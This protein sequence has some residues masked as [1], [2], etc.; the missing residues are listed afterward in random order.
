MDDARVSLQF[1]N[2]DFKERSSTVGTD[3]EHLILIERVV[4]QREFDRVHDVDILHP[5]LARRGDDSWHHCRCRPFERQPFIDAL[6][7]VPVS[8]RD[9]VRTCGVAKL[10]KDVVLGGSVEESWWSS[11]VRLWRNPGRREILI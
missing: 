3:H 4:T 10:M 7:E 2:D 9:A 5:V 11:L 1:R 8:S 6:P